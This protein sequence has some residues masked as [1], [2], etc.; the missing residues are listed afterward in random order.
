MEWKEV[1]YLL[2]SKIH[3]DL[4][5]T[6]NANFKIVRE[7][8]P[9]KCKNYDNVEG[10]RVQVGTKTFVNIPL[11]ML[12]TVFEET[13]KNNKTYNRAVFRDHFPRELNAKPCNVHAVGKLFEHA[14]IM[15]MIDKRTYRII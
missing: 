14:G 11:G 4:H 8:P 9:Y 2:K 13:L 7:V 6:P 10:F 1:K 12:Q 15:Q 5:L 3:L